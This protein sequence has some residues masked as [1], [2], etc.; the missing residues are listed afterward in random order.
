MSRALF[1]FLLLCG[2][3]VTETGNPAVPTRMGLTAFG[4]DPTVAAVRDPAAGG[5]VVEQAFVVFGD[6]RFVPTERCDDDTRIDVAGPLHVDVAADEVFVATFD[7]PE[8]TFCRVRIRL[9]R[10]EAPIA[11]GPPELVDHSV[12]IR[13]R[14]P[15]GTEFLLAS[16][17]T[18]E[19]EL[20][21][22]AD[23][24][25]PID[26]ARSAMLLAF[27][28]SVW[29][30][31]VDLDTGVPSGGRIVVDENMN[32]AL[33]DLFDANLEAALSL[34]SDTDEDGELDDVERSEV[35]AD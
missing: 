16:Q 4:S 28:V 18:E 30:A 6:M 10:G 9:E 5:V 25:F 17:E 27:D 1:L 15:A 2:C 20:R 7:V 32:G 23:G 31:G 34:F 3:D 24:P 22:D 33:L 21:N 8:T 13:G 14:T 11:V 26:E 35:L 29:F 12:V 19:L